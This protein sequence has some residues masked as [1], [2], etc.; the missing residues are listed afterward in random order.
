LG[1]SNHATLT[2][3]LKQ[4]SDK[5]TNR[6]AHW[7]ERLMPFARCMSSLYRKVSVNEAGA[8]S[9]R[10]DFFHPD[11]VHM[12]MPVEMFALWWDG[13]VRDMCYQCNDIALLVLSADIVSVDDDFLTKLKTTYSS[14]S[15]F[16]DENTRWKGHGLFK[17]FDGLNTTM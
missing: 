11:D 16:S 7:V 13:N 17:S 4:P 12:H 5:L 14:C 2:H 1:Q 3:L 9:R 15:Y 10:L 8:V 6:Q